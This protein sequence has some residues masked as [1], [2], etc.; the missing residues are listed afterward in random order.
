MTLGTRL[1]TMWRGE[2]VG[3]DDAGNRYFRDKK[4]R[5]GSRAGIRER[6]WVLYAGEVEASRVPPEWHAWLHHTAAEAP[7]GR[8][9]WAW[10]KEHQPNRTGTAEA[11]R[12]PGHV[13]EGGKRQPASGDYEPWRPS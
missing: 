10:Q 11:Y 5:S 4:R 8:A 1:F 12:P 9:K 13:L 2:H 6:R 3:D 7:D